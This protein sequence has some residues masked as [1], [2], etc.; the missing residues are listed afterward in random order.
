LP[1]L[2]DRLAAEAPGVPVGT[3]SLLGEIA[4]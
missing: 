4:L 1:R 2:V 3:L